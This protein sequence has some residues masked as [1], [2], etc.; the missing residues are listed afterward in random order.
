MCC[1]CLAYEN[2]RNAHVVIHR[3]MLCKIHWVMLRYLHMYL[4]SRLRALESFESL[5]AVVKE[6]IGKAV[7][8]RHLSH[9]EGDKNLT[10][11]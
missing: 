10:Y 8:F 5:F 6:C 2:I 1:E 9:T 7:T 4:H 11:C 3:V